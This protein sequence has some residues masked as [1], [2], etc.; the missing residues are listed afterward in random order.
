MNKIAFIGAGNMNRAI[1]A[2]LINNGF[3]PDNIIVSNP[4]PEKRLALA[5]EFAIHQTQ[6]NLEAANFAPTIV[7]G[8]KPHLI[9]GVCQQIRQNLEIS[10]KCFISIAAGCTMAQ[11]Q[12]ALGGGQSVIRTMPNTPSQ[13]GLGVTGIFAS[14][15]VS[16]S[17]RAIADEMMKAV[18][19]VMWLD[20][21]KQIDDIIAVSGSAPAN[22]FLFMEI[23]EQHAQT[24]GFSA[25]DSRKLVQQT[26]LGAAQMVCQNDDS[27]GQLR[28][29]VTSK[30]GATQA[31]LNQFYQGDLSQLVTKAMDAALQRSQEMAQNNG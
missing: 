24:L 17:E 23:M 13:L 22:F 14:A 27:I 19:I 30:G 3:A 21:E 4:S 18:G 7:L 20:Q 10:E 8:V 15:E 12:A 6:D 28:E 26:A 25:E 29:N 31:A 1:I 16:E 9:A 11:I 5:E 2:G